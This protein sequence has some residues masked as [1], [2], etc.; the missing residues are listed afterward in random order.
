MLNIIF[1]YKLKYTSKFFK[2]SLWYNQFKVP[3]NNYV[4]LSATNKMGTASC[5][6]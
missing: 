3:N 2:F 5:N 6:I 1:I 4:H